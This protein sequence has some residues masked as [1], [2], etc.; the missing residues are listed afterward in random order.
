MVGDNMSRA[1]HYFNNTMALLGISRLRI[2]DES[3]VPEGGILVAWAPNGR[4]DDGRMYLAVDTNDK[5]FYPVVCNYEN[6]AGAKVFL[7]ED[8][9]RG[10][11]ILKNKD[12]QYSITGGM[13]KECSPLQLVKSD[14]L[15]YGE[16]GTP[17]A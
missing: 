7:A 13:V 4:D 17:V 16:Y 9:D 3:D 10:V 14:S 1:L 2:G 12:I 6:V 8:P 15:S 11:Q 5:V